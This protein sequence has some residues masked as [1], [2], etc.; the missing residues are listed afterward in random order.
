M[1]V[2]GIDLG[3]DCGFAVLTRTGQR[4]ESGVWHFGK[5]KDG[6]R[7]SEV[8][9]SV[10]AL[11]QR[12]QITHGDVLAVG[13]EYSVNYRFS[14]AATVFGEYRGALKLATFE[15]QVPLYGANWAAVKK[16]AT[17]SGAA[18]KAQMIDAANARW[19]QGLTAKGHDEADA[20]WVADFVRVPLTRPQ[21]P[22]PPRIKR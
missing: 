1:Y 2:I 10:K 13:Y 15:A 8:V 9:R 6:E 22:A 4:V 14:S 7:M 5:Y 16:H 11:V 12:V 19:H 21:V 20:L 17:G 18:D 3:N